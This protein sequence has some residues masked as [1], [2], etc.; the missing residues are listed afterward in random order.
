MDTFK[1]QYALELKV[2]E[3]LE[4]NQ[5]C[6]RFDVSVLPERLKNN[7]EEICSITSAQPILIIQSL[8]CS[9]STL[10][11]KKCYIPEGQYFQQLYPNLWALSISL[12]GAFKTTALNY[13]GNVAR[14]KQNNILN[15]IRKLRVQQAS[16]KKDGSEFIELENHINALYKSNPIIP[17]RT[18][19]EGL[20]DLLADAP[21]GASHN[22]AMFMCS[23][24]GDW[25]QNV[26]KRYNQ[27]FKAMLTDCYDVPMSYEYLT[28]TDGVRTISKPFLT[29]NAVSTMAW[30]EQNINRSDITSGFFARFL[31]F[32]PPQDYNTPPALPV[33]TSYDR[34]YENNLKHLLKEI[35]K[36]TTVFHLSRRASELFIDIHNGLYCNLVDL[37]P[38]TEEILS[39]FIKRWSPYILKLSMIMQII[40]DP[41]SN[42]IS[43]NAVES[44]HAVV[45]YAIRSTLHLLKNELG[46]SEQQ[47][48]QR[49]VLQYIAQRRG[50]VKRSQLVSSKV[51]DGGSREYDN[52]IE[53]LESS[54][55]III[56]KTPAKKA[57][58]TY[59]L[60]VE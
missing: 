18:T 40:I 42:M 47:K 28:K 49:L 51:L 44:A 25:I 14:T 59:T 23:E 41:E 30:V 5:P 54:A 35:S 27:G 22:G 19:A 17:I 31:I 37:P 3:I 26:D 2:N 29:I 50:A 48:K 10:I 13:G 32:Y 15:Q 36:R 57:D 16:L 7:V 53:T 39:P 55:Q 11:G 56:N 58:H 46:E 4:S 45:D 12:S 60:Y 38:K 1:H 9:I 33:N 21:S 34:T 24:F 20:I 52:V 6:G 43:V 8:L